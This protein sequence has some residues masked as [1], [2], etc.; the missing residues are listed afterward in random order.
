MHSR[1]NAAIALR[2]GEEQL[3]LAA[4][5]QQLVHVVRGRRA[6]AGVDPLLE[7]G[8]VQQA[9][10]AVVDQLVLLALAQRLDGQPQLLLDLVHR[11]VVEVGDA[12]V[13]AQHRLRDAE[14]VLA[15]R[16]LVVDERAGQRR[17]A[18][19]AGRERRS[20]PRRTCSARLDGLAS[21]CAMCARSVSVW[22]LSRSNVVP[23]QHQH[24]ARGR[25]R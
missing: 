11:L 12:G 4:P 21:C 19:V 20:P 7:V 1:P 8:V 3:R 6:G 2:V 25:A 9:E 23:R 22:P 16:Q 14:L 15:R 10:L 18:V 5:R 17:L 13:D 24:G